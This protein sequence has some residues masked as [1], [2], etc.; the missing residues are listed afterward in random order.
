MH[1][2]RGFVFFTAFAASF[3][4]SS[5]NAQPGDLNFN[6]FLEEDNTAGAGGGSD[7][8]NGDLNFNPFLENGANTGSANSDTL[9][10]N[11]GNQLPIGSNSAST[12]PCENTADVE[13]IN[14]DKRGCPA[15][16]ASLPQTPSD[17]TLTS[18]PGCPDG[19]LI[20]VSS[21]R[22]PDDDNSYR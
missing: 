6:P 11:N 18:Q 3:L 22:S 16:R 5:V 1:N 10:E 15:Q 7:K 8:Q 12:C 13:S 17:I 9:N 14:F 19:M 2:L 20:Q 21:F 4:V